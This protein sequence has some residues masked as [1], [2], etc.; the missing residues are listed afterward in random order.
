MSRHL[1]DGP[2]VG[3][4]KERHSQ[5]DRLLVSSR[6]EWVERE[7]R[8]DGESRAKDGSSCAADGNRTFLG[9]IVFGG[10]QQRLV[11]SWTLHRQVRDYA[12]VE[13]VQIENE[14]MKQ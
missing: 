8:G 6:D 12:D 11:R 10:I 7:G 5:I 13:P 9:H 2:S 1:A 3:Q 14:W 4:T